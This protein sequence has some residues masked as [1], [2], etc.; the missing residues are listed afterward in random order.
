MAEETKKKNSIGSTIATVI[1]ILV[2]IF[3]IL[4]SYSAF[5]TKAGNGVPSIFGFEPFAVQSESMEPFFYKGDLIIDKKVTD[6]STLKEGDVITFWTFINGY[7]ALNTHRIVTVEDH[8]NYY[9]YITRGDHNPVNDTSFVHSRDVVGKYVTHIPKL[10][11]VL[12]FLQTSKGFFI[13][14]VLPVAIFFL[15]QLIAFFKTLTQYRTEKIKMQLQAE[16]AA[17]AD[18]A[19][20]DEPKPENEPVKEAAPV[21]QATAPEEK[22]EE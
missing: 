22:K 21:A 13:C 3:A 1:L 20:K 14:I 7:R 16:M 8:G 6:F 17:Q 2:I 12:D 9:T 4:I 10:G 11:S 5:T 19:K 18:A 15:Y